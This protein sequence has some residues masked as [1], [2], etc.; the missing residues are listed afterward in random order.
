MADN[1]TASCPFC[2]FTDSDADFVFQHIEFCHPE[3]GGLEYLQD[4]TLK[5]AHQNSASMPDDD[6]GADKY[7]DCPHGCGEVI[8]NAELSSHLDLHVAEDIAL[9]DLGTTAARSPT[10]PYSHDDD[11]SFDDEDSL[12]MLDYYKG[13]KRGVQR[14]SSRINTAKSPRPHSPPRT[15]NADGI[16]RLGV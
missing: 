4:K 7:V 5:I 8:A 10:D 12:D 6:Y 16:K 11:G 9:D 1:N 14:D 2:P 15:I 13:G 3:T